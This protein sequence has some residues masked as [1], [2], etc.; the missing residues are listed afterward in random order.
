MNTS[1]ISISCILGAIALFNSLLIPPTFAHKVEI[2]EDVGATL[3]IEPND[4][5][6]AGES[7]QVW[8][9][10]TKEGGNPI[11]LSK[12]DCKL[13]IYSEPKSSQPIFQPILK[14]L[15]TEGYKNI[16]SADVNF[17][18]VGRYSLEIAGKPIGGEDFKPFKLN[19]KVTVAT[20]IPPIPST[21]SGFKA[22]NPDSDD[23][24]SENQSIPVITGVGIIATAGVILILRINK[25]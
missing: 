1:Q 8:F 3:H 17:P 4:N 6:R 20:A 22:V 13:S 9:A 21:N 18:K 5:P 12:C 25:K 7:S 23:L 14:P 19:F 10:L 15:S 2:S 11:P 24:L 16:P